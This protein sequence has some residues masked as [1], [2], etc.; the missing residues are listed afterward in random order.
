MSA[1]ERSCF[2]QMRHLFCAHGDGRNDASHRRAIITLPLLE[3]LA[4]EH[5]A[6]VGDGAQPCQRLL[7]VLLASVTVAVA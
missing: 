1:S 3:Q 7:L 5:V 4:G 2:K 6:L